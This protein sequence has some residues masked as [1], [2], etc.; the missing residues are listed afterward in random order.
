MKPCSPLLIHFAKRLAAGLLLLSFHTAALA[1]G[2]MHQYTFQGYTFLQ[3]DVVDVKHVLAPFFLSFEEARAQLGELEE[4][5]QSDNIAEWEER[6]CS[7]ARLADIRTVVYETEQSDLRQLKTA[8][9]S[10]SMPLPYK[11]SDNSFASFLR[12]LQCDETI[13]YLIFAKECQKYAVASDPWEGRKPNVAAMQDLIDEGLQLFRNTGSHY[14][15]LRYTYQVVRMAHYSKQFQQ[16]LDLFEELMPM[17]DQPLFDKGRHSIIYY[18]TLG[19]KAGALRGLGRHVEASYLYAQIFRACPS[20][21]TSSFQSFLIKSDEEWEACLRLC[22]S[23]EER[24]NLFALRAHSADAR[25]LD[26]MERIYQYDPKHPDLEVLLLR[27]MQKLEK[28]LLGTEFNFRRREN[29]RLHK[30]PRPYAGTYVVSM[31][32]FA[33]RMYTEA[34]VQRPELWLLAEGYLQVLASDFYAAGKTFEDLAPKLKSKELRKQLDIMRLVLEICS[35]EEVTREVEERAYEL[36]KKDKIYRSLRDFQVL[37]R[38]KFAYQYA[39]EGRPGKAFRSHHTLR[40]LKLN[41]QIDIIDDLLKICLNQDRNSLERLFVEDDDK[42]LITNEL[43]NTKAMLL[44]Q[45]GQLEAAYRVFRNIPR[46]EWDDFGRFAPFVPMYLDCVHCERTQDSASLFNRGQLIETMLDYEFKARAELENNARFYYFL[47][48]AHYN[49]TYFG[50]NWDVMDHFRS[51]ATWAQL[52]KGDVFPY[53]ETPYGNRESLNM[54][55]ALYFFEQARLFSKNRELGARIAF[56]AAKC[57]LNQYYM[58]SDYV[59][60]PCCN[61]IPNVPDAYQS[62]F[63]RLKDDFSD[64]EFYLSILEE[65]LYFRAYALK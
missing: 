47:G 12:R 55:R 1:C 19:H 16:A 64:T 26:E 45:E 15:R 30:I 29:R 38:D 63:K 59:A 27:E 25:A 28:D 54:N 53:G 42:K 48:I 8:M 13:D 41:P 5:R 10:R 18:W 9:Q 21:R 60:P 36:R 43:Y 44:M 23:D 3:P 61:R 49:M 22:Q 40:D 57:E 52:G 6:I 46:S 20:R 58:S 51:G 32:R 37:A 34:A 56:M 14:I 62:N 7:N 39:L 35:I 11:L 17:I 50:S 2:P 24:A 31:Q 65:C 4:Q 33:H